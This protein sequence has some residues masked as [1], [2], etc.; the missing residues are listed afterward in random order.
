MLEARPDVKS[1]VVSCWKSYWEASKKPEMA[2]TVGF[3]YGFELDSLDD[4]DHSWIKAI[5]GPPPADPALA[6]AT[7]CV[8]SA[9]EPLAAGEGRKI[10]DETRWEAAVTFTAAPAR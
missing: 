10:G 5:D 2:V 1:A 4:F 9:I 7:G 3:R 6:S 8:R